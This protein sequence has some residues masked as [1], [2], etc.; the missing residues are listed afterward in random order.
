MENLSKCE[1]EV[2]LII[3]SLDEAPLN[4]VNARA[5]KKYAH[6]WKPQTVSTFLSR[7]V[8]KGYLTTKRKGRF[9]YYYPAIP[10]DTYC[11]KQVEELKNRLFDGSAEELIKCLQSQKE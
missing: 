6:E 4:M 2:L 1:E 8:R 5:N 10:R 7:L 9:T 3:Y 11:K